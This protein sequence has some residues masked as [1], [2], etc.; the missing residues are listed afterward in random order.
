MSH[1]VKYYRKKI[2]SATTEKCKKMDVLFKQQKLQ[3]KQLEC[4][5]VECETSKS[6][7][8]GEQGEVDVESEVIQTNDSEKG[9]TD[10]ESE[11][12]SDDWIPTK[13]VKIDIRKRSNHEIIFAWL[14]HSAA[15][16][17]VCNRL[18]SEPGNSSDSEIGE[19]S[20]VR[21]P[22]TCTVCVH[23]IW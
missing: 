9:E 13:K 23:G 17:S 20:K 2:S 8:P 12:E 16:E 22:S 6:Q 10:T 7:K 14:Y 3:N 5:Q 15:K 21:T 18:S 19:A 4:E 1:N 11:L